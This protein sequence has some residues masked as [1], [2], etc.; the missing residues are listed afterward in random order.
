MS[1]CSEQS[2][3]LPGLKKLVVDLLAG[4]GED[5]RAVTQANAA[6]SSGLNQGSLYTGSQSSN[7]G[8]K[9]AF[10]FTEPARGRTAVPQTESDINTG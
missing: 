9:P 10:A 2:F 6:V 1:F 5:H 3:N 7:M 8:S 4:E